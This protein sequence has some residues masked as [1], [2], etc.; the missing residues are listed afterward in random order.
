MLGPQ[1]SNAVLDLCSVTICVMSK[2]TVPV[3]Y[4]LLPLSTRKRHTVWPLTSVATIGIACTEV[5][6][7]GHTFYGDFFPC[8]WL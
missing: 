3:I 2:S 1:E 7:S 5:F 6:T 8:L 4:G